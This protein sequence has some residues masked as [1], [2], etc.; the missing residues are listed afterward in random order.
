MWKKYWNTERGQ[1]KGEVERDIC[2]EREE[3]R[4]EEKEVNTEG[5]LEEAFR[6]IN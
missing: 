6:R 2:S 4:K 5:S 3:G 1:L